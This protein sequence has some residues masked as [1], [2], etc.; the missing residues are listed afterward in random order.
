MQGSV[1]PITDQRQKNKDN[2]PDNASYLLIRALA[3][4]KV[5]TYTVF[6]GEN[7]TSDFNVRANVQYRF[8]ISILGNN[9][10]DT[11]FP[12]IHCKCG[13]I[14]TTITTVDTA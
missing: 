10:V 1:P 3:G 14:S 9:E 7:N 12:P 5:L 8:N 2:A 6:L 11:R 4:N 13:M